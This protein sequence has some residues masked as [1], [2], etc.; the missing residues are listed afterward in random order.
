V[1]AGYGQWALSAHRALQQLEP[2]APHRYL[3]IDVVASLAEPVAQLAAMNGVAAGGL[4]FTT[5]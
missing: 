4:D 1:G 5:G 3:L 2:G